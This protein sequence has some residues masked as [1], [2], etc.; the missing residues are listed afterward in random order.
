[1]KALFDHTSIKPKFLIF[2]ND[3]YKSNIGL[4]MTLL[5]FIATI[6]LSGY[7]LITFFLKK[8]FNVIFFREPNFQPII[9]LNNTFF[10]YYLKDTA[11][12]PVDPRIVEIVPTYWSYENGVRTIKYLET[13]PCDFNTNLN[14][15][16]EWFTGVNVSKF[17]CVKQPVNSTYS[18]NYNAD[19][20]RQYF[21]MYIRRCENSTA[22]GNFCYSPDILESKLKELNFYFDYYFPSYAYNHYNYSQPLTMKPYYASFKLDIS[23]VYIYFEYFKLLIYET[24]HGNVFDDYRTF[25]G[26]TYDDVSSKK[27][28]YGLTT[29]VYVPNTFSVI[30]I[31]VNTNYADRYKR[32]YSKLQSIVANIGGVIKFVF[33]FAQLITTY[34]TKHMMY[35]DISNVIIDKTSLPVTNIGSPNIHFHRNMRQGNLD[36]SSNLELNKTVNKGNIKKFTFIDFA[37]PVLSHRTASILY[38]SI[39]IVRRYLSVE[40]ILK[41]LCEYE[42]FKQVMLS[43]VQ[44]ELFNQVKLFSYEEH[45]ANELKYIKYNNGEVKPKEGVD[46][47]EVEMR[48]L[49]FIR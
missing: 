26:F 42:R 49:K 16:K 40:Y 1:M 6:V 5:S 46:N 32:F 45:V 11:Q 27:D 10:M 38:K 23:F 21:N 14:N 2:G 37:C 44:Y 47:N 4:I 34:I 31:N 8:D 7:F 18:L 3:R 41:T 24:D 12:N 29:K 15:Y 9:D 22:N 25:T 39:K 43:D 48:I 33:F 30:I 36:R 35:Y 19:G 20:D 28:I 13:E 17:N